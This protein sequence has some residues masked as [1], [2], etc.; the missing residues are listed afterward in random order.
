M[1]LLTH[2]GACPIL[3]HQFSLY[4]DDDQLM[5]CQGR[6]NNSELSFTSRKPALLLTKHPFV[7]LLIRQTHE[8]SK[9]SGINDTLTLVRERY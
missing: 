5:R 4:L 7:T 8:S 3:V 2:R 1:Y 6:I 9:H